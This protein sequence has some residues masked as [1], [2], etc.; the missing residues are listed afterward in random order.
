M[1]KSIY[2][3]IYPSIIVKI[4][5]FY[6]DRVYTIRNIFFIGILY[7]FHKLFSLFRKIHYESET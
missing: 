3:P 6:Y 2:L 4:Y 1:N 5:Q 7:I